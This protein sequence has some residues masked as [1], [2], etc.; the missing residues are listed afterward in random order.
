M[1]WVRL[2]DSMPDDPRYI[3][4]SD[5]AF[6]LH[7]RGLCYSNRH[8][9]DGAIPSGALARLSKA[10]DVTLILRELECAQRWRKTDT[11]WQ[12]EQYHDEQP[13]RES[14]LQKRQKASDRVARFREKKRKKA[15]RR[16]RATTEPV[17]PLLDDEKRVTESVTVDTC[18]AVGNAGCNAAPDPTRPGTEQEQEHTLAPL[19]RRTTPVEDL[20]EP[21]F[22]T[23]LAIA[24]SAIDAHPTGSEA[25]WRAT[26]KCLEQGWNYAARHAE[27][28][29]PL[30]DRA[31]AA[32][33]A[34]RKARAIAVQASVP[35]PV[36][37]RRTRGGRR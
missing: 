1:P 11:G 16:G 15:K 34:T 37:V 12:I 26:F 2:D 22:R 35:R 28:E 20:P 32:A 7:V 17:T 10:E 8:L 36:L 4:L 27:H 30:V 24:H 25:D 31:L 9:T 18:N 33:Q 23:A 3:D 14:V 21:D 13:T 5:G 19:P 29:A 6:A